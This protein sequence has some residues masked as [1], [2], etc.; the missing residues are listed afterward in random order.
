MQEDYVSKL[1][2]WVQAQQRPVAAPVFTIDDPKGVDH[3]PIWNS[4]TVSVDGKKFVA[5]GE[6][7]TKKEAKQAAAKKAYLSLTTKV[8]T[9]P[10]LMELRKGNA[11]IRRDFLPE[12]KIDPKIYDSPTPAEEVEVDEFL[13]L[14]NFVKTCIAID[15]DNIKLGPSD[16]KALVDRRYEVHLF[17]AASKDIGAMGN[18]VQHHRAPELMKEMTDHCLSWWVCQNCE[19]LARHGYRLIII[20]KDMGIKAVAELAK[21]QKVNTE[22]RCEL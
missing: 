12:L 4:G 9:P 1:N 8:H 7:R 18:S 10:T 17:Y 19:R 14:S 5:H 13:V 3:M 22:F 21:R 15:F 16:L 2:L 11:P 20:S 6:F